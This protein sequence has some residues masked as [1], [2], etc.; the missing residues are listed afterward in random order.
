MYHYVRP[1]DERYPGLRALHLDDFRR[2]LD[3]LGATV[4]FA[5]RDDVVAAVEGGA[6]LPDGCILTFDDGLADHHDHVL[7]ELVDRGL[8]GVF[9][10]PL[11]PYLDGRVL[12]VHRVHAL[13]ARVPADVLLAAVRGTVG[14]DDVDPAE[15]ERLDGQIYQGRSD[16]DA[17]TAV[18]TLL[19]YAVRPQRRSAVLAEVEAELDLRVSFEDWYVPAAGLRAMADAGMV[20]GSHAVSHR[21]MAQLTLD[22]QR[23]EIDRSFAALE[24]LVGSGR[25]PRTFCYPYG[26]FHTFTAE[27]ERLLTEAGVAWSFNVEPREITDEHLRTR[28]QALP[29]IDCCD[30]P[31]GRSRSAPLR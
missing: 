27:T 31:H 4:G 7:P 10:V 6:P 28:P 8:W 9:C 22:E 19:N 14:A 26:G 30:L 29:R 2:Q 18:R 25:G 24:S 15:V 13:L 21:A 17:E 11:G 20:L 12:D 23:D 1:A 16:G 5:A 3:H